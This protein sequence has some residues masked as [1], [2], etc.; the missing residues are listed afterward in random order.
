M[1]SGQSES[2]DSVSVGDE[3]IPSSSLFKNNSSVVDLPVSGSSSPF[4]SHSSLSFQ[5]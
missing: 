3:S 1:V 5:E 4:S 2:V